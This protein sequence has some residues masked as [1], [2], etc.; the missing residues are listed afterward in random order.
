MTP[1]DMPG[2]RLRSSATHSSLPMLLVCLLLVGA[3]LILAAIPLPAGIAWL[4]AIA[5]ATT[6]LCGLGLVLHAALR[7]PESLRSESH[8]EIIRP[9]R[10]APDDNA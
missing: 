3:G 8:S 5:G 7:R 10:T 9:V 4:S 6:L 1:R 2:E